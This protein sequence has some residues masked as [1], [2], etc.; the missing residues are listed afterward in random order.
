[1]IPHYFLY[2]ERS[3]EIDASFLHIEP[4]VV[5]SSRHDWI[6]R[7]H[8][9]PDHHQILL[10]SKGGGTIEVEDE[11]WRLTPGTLIMVPAMTVHGFRFKRG[12]NGLV[13]TVSTSYLRSILRDDPDLLSSLA[14]PARFLPQDLGDSIELNKVFAALEREFVWAAP[15]R[16][17]AIRAYLHLIAITVRRLHGK[18]EKPAKAGTHGVDT[19]LRFRELI[20]VSYRNHLPLSALARKLGITT[21]RL[22]ALCRSTTGKSSLELINDRLLVEA[23]R[24]LLY[25]S[26]NVAEIAASLGYSDPAYFNR[27]FSKS[28]GK[29]PGALRKSFLS[30]FKKRGL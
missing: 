4:I 9:H 1:M 15:G 19:V 21:A 11:A 5:R 23:K 2:Q 27:F 14:R 30:T 25:S 28:V 12:T 16:S 18:L 7:T 6:I 26:Q 20:E 17:A 24:K 13:I 8:T 22:N 29:S 3:Q 10:L